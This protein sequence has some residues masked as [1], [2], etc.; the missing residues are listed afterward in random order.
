LQIVVDKAM[1]PFGERAVAPQVG[2]SDESYMAVC[3]T[4]IARKLAP[5]R[6]AINYLKV[7]AAV[8]ARLL[9][10][11]IELAKVEGDHPNH[12]LADNEV[13]EITKLD[14]SGRPITEFHIKLGPSFWMD[15]FK[16]D[17]KYVSGGSA[18]IATEDRS[19]TYHF[20]KDHLPEIAALRQREAFEQSRVP[21]RQSISR[22]WPSSAIRRFGQGS[23]EVRHGRTEA[24]TTLR[25]RRTGTEECQKRQL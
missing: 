19:G 13:R 18:G 24:S 11:N 2:E 6:R 9:Q 12:S 1:A 23:R 16:G 21:N 20:S 17:G 7:P 22:C 14:R 4:Q 25:I 3:N 15:Q 5:E 8:G 10:E